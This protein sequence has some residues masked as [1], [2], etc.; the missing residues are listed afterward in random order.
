[1]PNNSRRTDSDNIISIAQVKRVDDIANG[2]RIKVRIDPYD[3]IYDTDDDLPYCFPLLPKLV[4]V[5]PKIGEYV[6][7]IFQNSAEKTGQRF[8]IGPVIS[9]DYDLYYAKLTSQVKSLLAGKPLYPPLINP[10]RNAE[11]IGTLPD[12]EDVSIRGRSNSDIILKP[13]EIRLR[14]GFLKNPEASD[15]DKK[16]EFNR[17]DLAYI[18]MKYN[19]N[20]KDEQGRDYSSLIN[21]VADRINLLSH[22]SITPFE[23]NDRN[24]LITNDML[25]RIQSEAHPLV[26]GDELINFLKKLIQVFRTHTHPFVMLPPTFNA[27]DTGTL[28][29][30]LDKMLS[31]AVKIN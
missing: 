23:L 29:T 5:Y 31:Q 13:S 26:Y 10:E 27:A 17:E 3:I 18:Q 25:E 16:L 9:Q 6:L 2:N 28:N 7:V 20:M 15:V 24:E 11:N 14:C 30:D 4:H 19:K 8:Y 21:I 12:R 1:M 22:D